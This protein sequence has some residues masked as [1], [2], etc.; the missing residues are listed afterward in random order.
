MERN[1]SVGNIFG[2]H[3]CHRNQEG[4]CKTTF[5][6]FALAQKPPLVRKEQIQEPHIEYSILYFNKGKKLAI[7]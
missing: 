6:I 2:L 4:S 7:K 5:Y 1:I 3:G